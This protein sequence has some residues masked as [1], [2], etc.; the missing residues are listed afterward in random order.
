MTIGR[1]VL[2]GDASMTH[3]DTRLFPVI[4]AA[5]RVASYRY[6]YEGNAAEERKKALSGPTV[7]SL[8][9]SRLDPGKTPIRNV[10][11]ASLPDTVRWGIV[12]SLSHF[13]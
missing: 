10:D 11:R 12:L 9:T 13:E 7:W 6:R 5:E 8:Q 4:R 3:Q 2:A 1:D